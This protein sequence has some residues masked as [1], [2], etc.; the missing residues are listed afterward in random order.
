MMR[1]PAIQISCERESSVLAFLLIE[2][3]V[4]FFKYVD[5]FLTTLQNLLS[6]RFDLDV[7]SGQC[8]ATRMDS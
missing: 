1:L 3:G 6:M 2:I 8:K 4:Q 7:V 5:P